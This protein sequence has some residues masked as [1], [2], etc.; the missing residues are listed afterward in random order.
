MLYI[1]LSTLCGFRH[2]LVVLEHIPMDKGV[3]TVVTSLLSLMVSTNWLFT[4]LCPCL[5]HAFIFFSFSVPFHCFP[6]TSSQCVIFRPG[7]F[8]FTYETIYE[9]C[10]LQTNERRQEDI[11]YQ[12]HMHCLMLITKC[13][14][15]HNRV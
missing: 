9:K 11:I 3:I 12:T 2:L 15:R 5:P 14:K 7:L 8:F 10:D 13:L 1:G 6:T 4:T